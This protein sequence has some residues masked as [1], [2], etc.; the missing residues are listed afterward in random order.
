MSLRIACAQLNVRVGDMAGNVE[1]IIGAAEQAQGRGADILLTSELSLC[2]YSPAD[3]LLRPAFQQRVDEAVESIRL[4][5]E[6]LSSLYWVVGYPVQRQARRFSA[7]G[8]FFQGRLIGEYLKAELTN[9]GVADERRYFESAAE[10]C[11]FG[12]R[13]VRCALLMS[14]DGW[15]PAP[16]VRAR[17][18]GA[19]LILRL[20]AS[21]YH[22]TGF[23]Q[24]LQAG[25]Q[26]ACSQGMAI[27]ACNPVGGQDE[28]LFDGQSHVLDAAGQLVGRARAFEEDL[29]LVDVEP[30][31][32][33]ALQLQARV[34]AAVDELPEVHRAL[35]LAIRD[36]VGKNGFGGVILGLSG[37]IDSALVAALAVDALGAE[38]V[39]TVMMPSPYTTDMSVQDA[40]DMARRLGIRHECWSIVPCFEA[41]RSTLAQTFAGLPEDTTEENIQARIRGTLLMALS[42]KTGWLVLTTSNKSE[43]AVGYST[44]YGDM[45]GGFAPLKDVSKTLVYRL[46]SYRNTLSEVIPERIIMRAPSAELR[47]DQKDQD[48]L[49]PYD[50]LD[51]IVTAYVEQN[52][53]ASELVEQ[54]MPAEAVTQ[55]VRLLRISE[56]KR[57]QGPIGPRI[58]AR[59]FGADWRYPITSGFRETLGR[60]Q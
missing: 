37:G 19:G 1:R 52:Q 16:A 3:D 6:R 29:L 56:Y 45:A 14:E 32:D 28:L 20:D 2:G 35:V 22:Q 47:P 8:V 17:T 53:S 51:R 50:L 49:P 9:H 24:R 10:P 27:V 36:Y 46:S 60:N 38:R 48:A 55:V 4:A 18:A 42:N 11:V 33:G 41:F 13:G 54:G 40:E 58:T 12:I 5:S 25:R 26:H 34:E 44:L 57:Q 39:R 15:H 43:V 30:G 7:A 21:P 59:A 23:E 31:D